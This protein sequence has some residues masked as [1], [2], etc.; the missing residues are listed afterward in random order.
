MPV[1]FVSFRPMVSGFPGSRF[2]PT[3]Q[4]FLLHSK[5]L[6]VPASLDNT[7]SVM[8]CIGFSLFLASFFMTSPPYF[9]CWPCFLPFGTNSLVCLPAFQ[10]L[11]FHP[12]YRLS[13]AHGGVLPDSFSFRLFHFLFASPFVRLQSIFLS[14]SF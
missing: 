9:V 10:T 12:V 11:V 7:L 2:R 6:H 5:N 14:I 8:P 1:P 3:S 4:V 13:W